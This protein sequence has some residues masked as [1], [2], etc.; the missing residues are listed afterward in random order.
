MRTG[1]LIKQFH[2]DETQ[3]SLAT[4]ILDARKFVSRNGRWLSAMEL[5]QE[6]LTKGLAELGL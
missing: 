1:G 3:Q 6:G 2:F 4:N 5:A